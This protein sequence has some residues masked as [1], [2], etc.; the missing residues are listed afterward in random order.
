[1]ALVW[2]VFE[3]FIKLKSIIINFEQVYAR[4]CLCD[5]VLT[6]LKDLSNYI[7]RE[8][9]RKRDVD[10]FLHVVGNCNF[11]TTYILNGHICFVLYIKQ[12]F[13]YVFLGVVHV[14]HS[15]L[16]ICHL[17]RLSCGKEQ[18]EIDYVY[19]FWW[20][21]WLPFI[22]LHV[23]LLCHVT[24]KLDILILGSLHPILNWRLQGFQR[25]NSDKESLP[26]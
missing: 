9:M 11:R 7:Q 6:N 10:N 26:S 4:I 24:Y 15:Y 19:T 3:T 5:A 2:V 14:C 16:G 12:G 21:A 23:Q 20:I 25:D 1:M 18:F 17:C 8:K 22:E 13:K